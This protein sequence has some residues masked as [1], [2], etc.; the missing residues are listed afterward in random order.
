VGFFQVAP[1]RFLGSFHRFHKF[2]V[3][4]TMTFLH[5][6]EQERFENVLPMP[7][8]K[9]TNTLSI[10]QVAEVLQVTPRTL[11]NWLKK[12]KIAEP[13]RHPGNRYRLWSLEEVEEIRRQRLEE[14]E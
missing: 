14:M 3:D 11:R 5:I 13:R 10:S 1:S 2:Y 4:E 7:K 12:K 9:N 8:M 6:R